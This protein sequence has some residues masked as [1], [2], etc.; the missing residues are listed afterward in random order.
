M[1]LLNGIVSLGEVLKKV[2]VDSDELGDHKQQPRL[3][4]EFSEGWG[5]N[6]LAS[7]R[8]RLRSSPSDYDDNKH[9]RPR[10][11]SSF[12]Q[13]SD[14]ERATLR[15]IRRRMS[16]SASGKSSAASSASSL[17]K[18]PVDPITRTALRYTLSPREYEL[19]HNYL[20]S[21]A[22]KRVQK[23]TPNPPRFER[24]T[25]ASSESGDYNVASVR[26][27]L[28]VYLG[29]FTAL[30]SMDFVM[31]KIAQRRGTADVKAKPA[32]KYKNTRIALSFSTILLFHRLLHRFFKRLRAALLEESAEPFRERNPRISKALTS[33]YTPAIGASL[34]GCF[35]GV[36]PAEQLRI[37]VAIYVFS[38]SMEYGYNALST[39]GYIWPKGDRPWWFGSWLVMPFACGQLLHAFVFDRDCFPDSYGQ[40]IL[41]R[42]PEYIQSRPKDYPIGKSWPAT[43]DIVDG[44][45][46]LSKLK[47]P[48]FTSPILFPGKKDTLPKGIA[49]QKLAPISGPAHPGTKYTSCAFLHPK[50]PSCARTYLKYWIAAFPGVVKF[51]TLIY[52]AF[53]LLAYKALVKSPMPVLN[54]ISQR[55]LKMSLFITGAI[56]TSWGSI[57]LFNNILPRSVLPTQ[58][59]FLGGFLGGMWAWVARSQERDNFLYSMR[60]SID[61]LYKVGKKRGW[62]KGL[63]NGDVLLF[64]ASLAMINFVYEIQPSAVQGGLI[65]KVM[66]THR[67][68]GWVDKCA[69]SKKAKELKED[70]IIE[71]LGEEQQKAEKRD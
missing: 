8:M 25:K 36:A 60:L 61:S 2:V 44:L 20:I 16:S 18:R 41:K 35:L 67:G 65:R 5:T 58:R 11:S 19:L 29:L 53:G 70:S 37:T 21:K 28:R 56:G 68:E 69:S 66:S 6:T 57:C 40:F 27:A 24:I 33:K 63:T 7:S 42:S 12:P 43:F 59:L 51:F 15:D 47:W 54:K 38:R 49:I 52:G 31:G 30:K 4:G 45:A 9:H 22:P 3:F 39:S 1:P 32:P 26:A 55:I 50:D 46:E 23:Q 64:V 71:E 17:S 62:W 14:A 13:V 34:A 48:A 10:R